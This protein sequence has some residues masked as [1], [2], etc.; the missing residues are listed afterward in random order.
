EARI[1]GLDRAQN[2]DA[3]VIWGPWMWRTFYSLSR[4]AKQ[5]GI[6]DIVALRDRMKRDQFRSMEWIGLAVRW[7]DLRLR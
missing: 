7:A 5:S 6:S 3:Q 2:G 1:R 4:L